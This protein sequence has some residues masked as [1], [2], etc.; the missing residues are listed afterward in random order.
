[1]FSSFIHV[2]TEYIPRNLG[3][4]L[5]VFTHIL[6]LDFYGFINYALCWYRALASIIMDRERFFWN[7]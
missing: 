1:M 6:L 3:V 2:L 5:R 4:N 7:W